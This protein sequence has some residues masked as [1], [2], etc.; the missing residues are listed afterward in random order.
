MTSA[1]DIQTLQRGDGPC[2]GSPSVLIG[3][4]ARVPGCLSK[5][6]MQRSADRVECFQAGRVA[7]LLGS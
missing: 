5:G 1:T 3:G 6:R 7:G 4:R 2:G